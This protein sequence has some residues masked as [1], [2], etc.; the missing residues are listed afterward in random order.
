VIVGDVTG[1]GVTAASMTALLRH[2][3]RFASRSES[4]PAAI[5]SRLDE[6]LKQQPNSSLCTALCLR[7]HENELVICSAGH[8]PAMLVSNSGEVRESPAPG[9]LLGAFADAAWSE[10]TMT[11]APG[12]LVLLYTD[13]VTE[14]PGDGE[15]FGADRLRALLAEHAGGSP[16][17]MLRHVER[18][19][20]AYRAGA[21]RDDVAAVALRPRS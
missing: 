20:Q 13:G 1:K 12:E 3:A 18:G 4:R 6:A 2:G 16:S 9:P 11:V 21:H 5:L 10:Q 7:L 19:L 17:E 14:T 15:R 8:P